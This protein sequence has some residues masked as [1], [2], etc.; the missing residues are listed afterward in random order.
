MRRFLAGLA[1]ASLAGA[2]LVS[3]PGQTLAATCPV[4]GQTV[5][6]VIEGFNG[7]WGTA[8]QGGAERRVKVANRVVYYSAS[9][10][11]PYVSVD[12]NGLC[13]TGSSCSGNDRIPRTSIRLAVNAQSA[14]ATS[15]SP[16]TCVSFSGGPCSAFSTTYGS[17]G[18]TTNGV[19][20][21][22]DPS[23]A[24]VG[25]NP[26]AAGTSARLCTSLAAANPA[27]RLGSPYL[28]VTVPAAA[29]SGTYTMTIT[30]GIE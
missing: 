30:F 26:P 8:I 2:L 22:S 21:F 16:A 29:N 20:T 14:C 7:A 28:G 13:R 1:S 9:T 15:S 5:C 4:S 17:G 23:A 6:I 24:G 25:I 10:Y 12:A 27:M 18:S 11:W 3:A 19:F